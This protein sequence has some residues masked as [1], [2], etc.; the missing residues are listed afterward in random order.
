MRKQEPIKK[1]RPLI[2]TKR[3]LL[4]PVIKHLRTA[5]KNSLVVF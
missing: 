4:T 3:M 1:P 5:S 2:K